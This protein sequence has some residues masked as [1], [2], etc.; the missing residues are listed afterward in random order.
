M[1]P[2]PIL[3][4]LG[5]GRVL[6]PARLD[7]NYK[8]ST[9]KGRGW[10]RDYTHADDRKRPGTKILTDH[11]EGYHPDAQFNEANRHNTHQYLRVASGALPLFGIQKL[12]AIFV[13]DGQLFY[14]CKIY[15][16]DETYNCAFHTNNIDCTQEWLDWIDDEILSGVAL[17]GDLYK[18]NRYIRLPDDLQERMEKQFFDP[19]NYDDTDYDAGGIAHYRPIR[20]LSDWYNVENRPF[21]I[22][23]RIDIRLITLERAETAPTSRYMP[24]SE[25][26]YGAE[27]LARELLLIAPEDGGLRNPGDAPIRPPASYIPSPPCK[28][29]VAEEKGKQV[30]IPKDKRAPKK[31]KAPK[32]VAKAKK[33]EKGKGKKAAS[34]TVSDA[35]DE[36]VEEEEGRVLRS[37]GARKVPPKSTAK[38]LS[39]IPED[40]D[41]MLHSGDEWLT[42]V[43]WKAKRQAAALS[44][45]KAK[46]KAPAPSPRP[47]PA[48]A[49][50]V[51]GKHHT[52]VQPMSYT[53]L[54]R[55]PSPLDPLTD[56]DSEKSDG[57]V[58]N[59]TRNVPRSRSPT[60]SAASDEEK[61]PTMD[62]EMEEVYEDTLRT[63]ALEEEEE[64]EAFEKVL[65]EE[66]LDKQD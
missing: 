10:L 46:R 34:P 33:D 51:T 47:T 15:G 31:V 25:L 7:L 48:K 52:R 12:I 43:G 53:S 19:K 32:N 55:T 24:A 41:E 28:R 35:E 59:K 11:F 40:S 61:K 62:T 23:K 26:E 17:H 58:V 56:D 21:D 8:Y 20:V 38:S 54:S 5:P 63:F 13:K 9:G 65:D 66:V 57:S 4:P 50:N 36:S 39:Q 6:R 30:L 60:Q 14:V 45:R 49:Q 2:G 27:D 29:V 64:R 37:K 42:V 3:L 18:K 22:T 44:P 1:G 16:W